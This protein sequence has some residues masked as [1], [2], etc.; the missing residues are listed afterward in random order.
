MDVNILRHLDTQKVKGAFVEFAG[1]E[2]LVK[3]L[4]MNGEV[5]FG[6]PFHG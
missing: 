6:N 1:K 3:A 4:Q 5:G 2:D